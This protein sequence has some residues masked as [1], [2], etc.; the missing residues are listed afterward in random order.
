MMDSLICIIICEFYFVPIV[1][2][3]STINSIVF[4]TE[5]TPTTWLFK[6]SRLMTWKVGIVKTMKKFIFHKLLIEHKTQQIKNKE[7]RIPM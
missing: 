5:M 1:P 4:Q 7:Y 6:L 2:F 3:S